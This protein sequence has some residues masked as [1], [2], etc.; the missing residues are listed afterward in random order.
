MG[1]L[2][3]DEA[4]LRW[5]EIKMR[6]R[7]EGRIALERIM[8]EVLG[9]ADDAFKQAQKAPGSPL[10]DVPETRSELQEYFDRAVERVILAR[11]GQRVLPA[12]R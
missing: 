8:D 3:K 1:Y 10:M 11:K 5:S 9:E 4:G 7:L 2:K 6:L 12:K